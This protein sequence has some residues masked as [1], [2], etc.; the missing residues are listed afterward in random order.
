MSAS[1]ARLTAPSSRGSQTAYTNCANGDCYEDL[2]NLRFALAEEQLRRGSRQV[3]L[4]ELRG[5]DGASGRARL[6]RGRAQDLQARE[7]T[8]Q[9]ERR[10]EKMVANSTRSCSKPWNQ[11]QIGSWT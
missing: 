8:F 9:L 10:R 7:V 2:P 6:S 1:G 5:N 4:L 11:R 3:D